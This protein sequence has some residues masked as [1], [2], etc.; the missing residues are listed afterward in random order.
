M[1]AGAAAKR[2]DLEPRLVKQV[3]HP[4]LG[5]AHVTVRL[6]LHANLLHFAYHD[7]VQTS[8]FP[9]WRAARLLR[10]W[11]VEAKPTLSLPCFLASSLKRACFFCA[12]HRLGLLGRRRLKEGPLA[13]ASG[14]LARLGELAHL[15]AHLAPRQITAMLTNP[16]TAAEGAAFPVSRPHDEPEAYGRW[17]RLVPRHAGVRVFLRGELAIAFG[18]Q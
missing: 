9:S 16:E 4:I 15:S 13:E 11:L 2:G 8:T 12:S 6:L 10:G 18:R 1:V 17:S 5:H 14:A 7:V 3:G